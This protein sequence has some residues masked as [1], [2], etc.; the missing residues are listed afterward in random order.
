MDHVIAHGG[1]LLS[2]PRA[3]FNRL[4]LKYGPQLNLEGCTIGLLPSV[5]KSGSPAGTA[6][7]ADGVIDGVRLLVAMG[8]RESNFGANLRPRHETAYDI[9]GRFW[10]DSSL[11]QKYIA[12]HG[13]DGA[14]S[15]GPLQIM[16]VN[17][18]DCTPEQLAADADLAMQAAVEFLNRYVLGHWHARTLEAICRTYNGGNPRAAT[19]AGY[20]EEVWQHYL[21]EVIA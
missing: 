11:L 17:A 13:W 14:C 7:V 15:Y 19:T 4:C 8:G 1:T 2:I 12:E 5:V 21:T 20:T 16:A 18:K 6:V 9:N 3:E 10:R